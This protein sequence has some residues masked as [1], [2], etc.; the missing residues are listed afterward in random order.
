MIATYIIYNTVLILGGGLAFFSEWQN[1][2][3]SR[4]LLYMLSFLIVFFPM[5]FRYQI[6]TDYENYVY[7]FNNLAEY[8]LIKLEPIYYALNYVIKYLGMDVQ[9]VFILT[10]FIFC[11]FI[12]YTAQF[13]HRGW[14]ITF[15]ILLF[16][17]A[18]FNIVRQSVALSIAF[19]ALHNLFNNRNRN[20][21]FFIFLSLGF[22]YSTIIFIPFYFIRNIKLSWFFS[23]VLLMLV[24]FIGTK[25]NISE[26][27]F[28]NSIFQ[29]SKYN[30]Y[31][32]NEYNRETEV[33][34]G[35][36]VI[37]QLIIPITFILLSFSMKNIKHLG[38]VIVLCLSFILML[39]LTLQVYIFTRILVLFSISY[40]FS[41]AFIEKS[42]LRIRYVILFG[43]FILNVVFFEYTILVAQSNLGSGLGISPY[44]TIL[45]FL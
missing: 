3:L 37:L 27:I 28:N 31:A 40:L 5:A 39:Y 30:V 2:R 14:I 36:G 45:E 8:D 38:F 21:L 9:W 17:L 35:I 12:Y 20:F 24:I 10:S 18:S 22:H 11:Y 4:N 6:G 15:F 1:N 41:I 7:I 44:R 25:L 23:I 32:T 34:S 33:K 19:Y 42:Q 26:T 43:V 29:D 13:Y 16:Y